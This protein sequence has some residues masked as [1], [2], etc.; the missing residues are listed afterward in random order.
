[1]I[2]VDGSSYSY[3]AMR[4][5]LEMAREFG[6][7]LYVCRNTTGTKID[8]ASVAGKSTDAA[9]KRHSTAYICA[10]NANKIRT[11]MVGIRQRVERDRIIRASLLFSW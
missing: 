7:S 5:A 3:K 2:C 1:M 11:K 6:A 9:S 8:D 10:A 4:V